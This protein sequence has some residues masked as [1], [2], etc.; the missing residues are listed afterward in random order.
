MTHRSR[1]VRRKRMT[2]RGG[3]DRFGSY[4]QVG[5]LTREGGKR[6]RNMRGGQFMSMTKFSDGGRKRRTMR[7]GFSAARCTGMTCGGRK[8]RTMRGGVDAGLSWLG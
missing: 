1:I 2:M 7:G 4:G 6:R 3:Y 8:R 5:I